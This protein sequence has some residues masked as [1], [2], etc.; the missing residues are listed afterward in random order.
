MIFLAVV[1]ALFAGQAQEE[2]LSNLARDLGS[3]E[4]AVRD[5]AAKD[6]VALGRPALKTLREIQKS[7]TDPEIRLRAGAVIKDITR[8]LRD[9]ALKIDVTTDK[10]TYA[11]GEVVTAAV[12]LKNVEDFPVTIF[13][14]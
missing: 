6:L 7:A 2:R 1:T 3:A 5:R 10:P 4:A 13:L 12:C 14:G 11:P 9:S 8:D